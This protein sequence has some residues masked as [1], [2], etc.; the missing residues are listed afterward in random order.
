MNSYMDAMRRYV[1]FRGRTGRKDFW[2][3]VLVYFIIYIIAAV[4]D[5]VVFGRNIGQTLG[6]LAGVVGLI[7]LVP[8]LAV[9]VRRLHDTD[10]SGWW[11]LI[12]LVPLI[13]WIWLIVLY[14][15][16]GTPGANRFG[17]PHA[18]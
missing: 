17:A 14:C 1:D 15:Y 4:I 16:A 6:I 3:Y 2:I 18:A 7:H 13:G 9:S 11:I 8:G 10:R 5:G 12:C